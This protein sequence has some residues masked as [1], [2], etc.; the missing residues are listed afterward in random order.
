MAKIFQ[1]VEAA[2]QYLFGRQKAY[3]VGYDI[4]SVHGR[5]LLADIMEFCHYSKSTFHADPRIAA[6]R[7][8]QR[9]VLL[10]VL[11]HLNLSQEELAKLRNV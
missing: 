8:G 10:R 7:D 6:F 9:S 5:I 3:Q 2:R 4:D 1:G 11:E